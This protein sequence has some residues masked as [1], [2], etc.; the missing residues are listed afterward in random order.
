MERPPYAHKDNPEYGDYRI[1]REKIVKELRTLK[2][3]LPA[4]QEDWD[5]IWVLS[6][7]EYTLDD[8]ASD[9]Q[10]AEPWKRTPYNQS[11]RRLETGFALVKSVTALRLKKKLEELTEEDIKSH[12]PQIY[13]N[14]TA[15]GNDILREFISEGEFERRYKIPKETFRVSGNNDIKNT[16]HQFSEF[17]AD[18]VSPDKKVVIVTDLYHMSRA[19]RLPKKY[20]EKFAHLNPVFY[21]AQPMELP[22]NITMEDIRKVHGYIKQ[23]FLPPEDIHSADTE[24]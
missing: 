2:E 21:P 16:D 12:G 9:E 7:P 5:V 22:L 24:E 18:M 23:G 14:G 1:L 6:G 19:T 13:Y 4:P 11:K 8:S 10:M 15:K 20:P 3:N 17:P